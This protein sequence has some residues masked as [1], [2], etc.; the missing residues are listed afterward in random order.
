MGAGHGSPG[1]DMG[2]LLPVKW[3]AERRDFSHISSLIA[4][5]LQVTE[6]MLQQL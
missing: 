4:T 1:G 6:Q 2:E 5:K 3:E